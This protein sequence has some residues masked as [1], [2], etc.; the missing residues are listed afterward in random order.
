MTSSLG[1]RRAISRRTIRPPTPESKMPIGEEGMIFFAS[2]FSCFLPIPLTPI[3][4]MC[5]TSEIFFHSL[6][7]APGQFLAERSRARPLIFFFV[8][9]ISRLKQNRGHAGVFDGVNG[10]AGEAAVFF[11][12]AAH[13]RLVHRLGEPA[14]DRLMIVGLAPGDPA[15]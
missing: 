5:P 13:D 6:K 1:R 2:I 14:A 9:E 3:L 10:D 7:D 12:D 15:V 11:P 4:L 8:R